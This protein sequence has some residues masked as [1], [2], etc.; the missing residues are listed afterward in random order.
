M[1]NKGIIRIIF[2]QFTV[3]IYGLCVYLG[4][5][6]SLGLS[7]NIDESADLEAARRFIG[8]IVMLAS[9][10]PFANWKRPTTES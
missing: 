7:F 9:L 4:V 6:S 3:V 8:F 5:Y 1:S 10:A 2:K